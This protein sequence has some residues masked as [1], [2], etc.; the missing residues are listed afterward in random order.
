MVLSKETVTLRNLRNASAESSNGHG[1]FSARLERCR[2]RTAMTL[3][4]DIPHDILLSIQR[5]LNLQENVEGNGD[6]ASLS[7][8]FSPVGVLNTL[9]PD[10]AKLCHF[11]EENTS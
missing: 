1:S 7:S 11:A 9:F 10:G 4:M 6:L 2:L 3:E 5:I 8:D